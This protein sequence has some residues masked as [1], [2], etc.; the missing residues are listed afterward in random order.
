MNSSGVSDL[1]CIRV[2]AHI[3]HDW[4]IS[5][6]TNSGFPLLQFIGFDFPVIIGKNRIY[7]FLL[8]LALKRDIH[9]LVHQQVRPVLADFLA[10]VDGISVAFQFFDAIPHRITVEVFYIAVIP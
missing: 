10:H 1:C 2:N 7:K 3:L 9:A 8:L 6:C 5:N 4:N